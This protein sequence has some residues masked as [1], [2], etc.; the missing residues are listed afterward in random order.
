ML[1][2]ILSSSAFHDCHDCLFAA[3]GL[4]LPILPNPCPSENVAPQKPKVNNHPADLKEY[5]PDRTTQWR[6]SD[7]ICARGLSL[8]NLHL[9]AKLIITFCIPLTQNGC[10]PPKGLTCKPTDPTKRFGFARK[11]DPNQQEYSNTPP[12]KAQPRRFG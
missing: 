1:E 2:I 8:T 10:G 7:P 4:V 11:L 3:L 12:A 5:M 6:K 9:P